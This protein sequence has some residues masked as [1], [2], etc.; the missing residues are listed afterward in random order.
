ML[1]LTSRVGK[2][3]FVRLYHSKHASVACI[4]KL[5]KLIFVYMFAKGKQ[6][7]Q[8]FALLLHYSISKST[9][10]IYVCFHIHIYFLLPA[11]IGINVFPK[12]RFG[13]PIVSLVMS[14]HLYPLESTRV[15]LCSPWEIVNSDLWQ[16]CF[17]HI[18]VLHV[19]IRGVFV[20]IV[21]LI[22]V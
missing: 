13:V 2:I 8:S 19:I 1:T 14:A 6:K 16:L 12:C 17:L 10:N 3:T 15:S 4:R 20:F 9:V 7:T 5:I 22:T 18:R 21:T 11:C